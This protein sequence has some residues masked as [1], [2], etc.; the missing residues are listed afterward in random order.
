[1]TAG[2]ARELGVDGPV[3]RAALKGAKAP[4]N[5]VYAELSRLGNVPVDDAF[6]QQI[7]GIRN[8]GAG[9]FA[10]DMPADI[11]HLKEG[12]G[13]LQ[14]FDAGDAV[15]KVRQLRRDA[16]TNLGARYNP[17]QQALGH[18]QRAVA[19][20]I[21]GQLERHVAAT[22]GPSDLLQRYRAAR[23]QLAKI[24]TVEQALRA[25]KGQSVSALN[26]GKQLDRGA[27][28]SGNLRAI[29][30]AAQHFPRALQDLSKIRDAGPFS[31]LDFKLEGGLGLLKPV[32]A[33]KALPVL[34]AQPLMRAFLGSDLYQD[35]A[36]GGR[37][38]V[39]PGELR[40]ASRALPAMAADQ[41]QK[42]VASL[43]ARPPMFGLPRALG[44]PLAGAR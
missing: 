15:E 25:G 30:E 11:A 37:P 2:A 34:A 21:E 31:N 8:P 38:Y 3:T 40:L 12:Y 39:P 27:P 16:N 10:F 24:N 6:R 9:S 29:A 26:L 22:S 4:A 5:A 23:V 17:G 14:N 13:A 20:A 44:P 32:A 7:A 41:Y 1:V 36:F 18:A 33:L 28:L 43:L 35:A 19:D 42:G